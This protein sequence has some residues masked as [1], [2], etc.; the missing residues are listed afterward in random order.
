CIS[1]PIDN[2]KIVRR[3]C[4]SGLVAEYY[5]VGNR[6]VQLSFM[7]SGFTPDPR[8]HV[9]AVQKMHVF[10]DDIIICAYPKSG[11]H[12]VYEMT[13][14]LLKGEA[15][16]DPS[17][18]EVAMLEFHSLDIFDGM[19]RPRVLNSHN[20]VSEIPRGYI[21]GK[22]KVIFVQRNPKDIV[23][24]FYNH[25]INMHAAFPGT[26]EDFV[27]F[28]VKYGGYFSDW[29]Q[30]TLD[31]DE[32]LKRSTEMKCLNI[33]YEDIKRHET[34]EVSQIR[35]GSSIQSKILKTPE[36]KHK[37]D[38]HIMDTKRTRNTTIDFLAQKETHINQHDE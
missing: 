17:P 7:E 21:D 20:P 23:V 30:Y 15:E 16:Y 10:P 5:P 34:Q 35:L 22:G 18:K 38:E 6:F 12:W 9:S 29:F 25:M 2:D 33:Y 1:E 36:R 14:M 27:Y 37:T 32:E 19:S 28:A 13:K 4:P 11:T 26:W 8:T 31:F 3:E 24:S